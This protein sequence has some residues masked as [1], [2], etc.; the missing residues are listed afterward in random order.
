MLLQ[1]QLLQVEIE[2]L[3]YLGLR[4][5]IMAVLQLPDIPLPLHLVE[6]LATHLPGQQ[7]AL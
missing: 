2:A 4:Q 6:Q 7:A 1:L 5:Q 3:R